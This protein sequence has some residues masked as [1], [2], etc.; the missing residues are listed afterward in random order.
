[1]LTLDPPSGAYRS[2]FAT[3]FLCASRILPVHNTS[4][5]VSCHPDDN[6]ATYSLFSQLD[7]EKAECHSLALL[8]SE[9]DFAVGGHVLC[10]RGRVG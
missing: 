1:M 8:F 4:L 7:K 3:G 5:C 6:L 10:A 2:G 9:V